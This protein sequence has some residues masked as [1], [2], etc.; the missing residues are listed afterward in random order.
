MNTMPSRKPKEEMPAQVR[1]QVEKL[2]DRDSNARWE[3]AQLLSEMKHLSSA[4]HLIKALQDSDEAVRWEAAEAL[5]RIGHPSAIPHLVKA[6]QD[7]HPT[8]RMFAADA[9]GEVT[10]VSAVPHLAKALQDEHVNVRKHAAIAL[11]TIGHSIQGKSVRGKEARAL[12]LVAEHFHKPE[13]PKIIRKALLAALEGKVTAKN[14][15]LYIKQ[16]HALQG[17]VK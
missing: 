3:A 4:P 11:G 8:V 17:S 7:P 2:K 6:L 10:H 12:Q 15:R 5:G 16:L 1:K 13:Q 9:L 14:V